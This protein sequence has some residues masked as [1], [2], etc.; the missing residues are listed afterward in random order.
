M[1]W[2]A[3][4]FR[5]FDA[6]YAEATETYADEAKAMR[7]RAHAEAMATEQ[8]ERDTHLQH[9]EDALSDSSLSV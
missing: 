6:T 2:Y 9:V 7:D 1:H 4:A 5:E 8:H 3:R